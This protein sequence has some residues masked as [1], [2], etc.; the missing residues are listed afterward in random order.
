[1]KPQV[2]SFLLCSTYDLPNTTNLKFWGY[3][4]S[5]LCFLCKSDLGTL[6]NVLSACPHLLPMYTW[7]HNKVLKVIMELL[8][9]QCEAANKQSVTAKE[10]IIQFHK[11]GECPV[12]KQRHSNM[13]LLNGA[14]DWKVSM[15]LKTSL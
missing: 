10:P 2:I 5:D 14:S 6:R 12:R 1:M 4:D 7:Q 8:R 9:A 13:K 15:D 11:E 3:T